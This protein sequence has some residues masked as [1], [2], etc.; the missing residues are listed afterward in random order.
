M[1]KV[2][3]YFTNGNNV[4]LES[5]TSRELI[6]IEVQKRSE[7]N[8]TLNVHCLFVPKNKIHHSKAF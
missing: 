2:L 8:F 5:P 1:N 4:K 6:R 3:H 7:L